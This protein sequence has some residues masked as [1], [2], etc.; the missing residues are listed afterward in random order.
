[1]E[2]I[3]N[4]KRKQIKIQ[5]VKKARKIKVE[6]YQHVDM[7]VDEEFKQPPTQTVSGKEVYGSFKI[8]SQKKFDKDI[9]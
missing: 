3:K 5:K 2:T 7:E 1:M 4:L 6:N 9:A 8:S